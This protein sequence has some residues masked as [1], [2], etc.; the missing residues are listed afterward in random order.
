MANNEPTGQDKDQTASQAGQ[1]NTGDP[2]PDQ[3]DG[4][5]QGDGDDPGRQGG[6]EARIRQLSKMKNQYQSEAEHWKNIAARFAQLDEQDTR[7]HQQQP[8]AQGN[9]NQNQYGSD[10]VERAYRVLH[11]RG[12]ATTEDLERLAVRMKWDRMHD[13]NERRYNKRGNRYP[14]YNREEVEEYARTH[15]IGDPNAAYRDMYFDEILDAVKSDNRG[16]PS[17]S[18]SKTEKPSRPSNSQKEPLTLDGFKEKLR[19]DPGFYDKL[20]EDPA[21]FD[22]MLSDLSEAS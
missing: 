22:A 17:G 19:E 9:Q 21:R 7:G 5:G 4:G 6:A 12:M 8:P 10:E 1:A 3:S 2:E 18:G 14:E 11:D 13:Q 20:A 16:R 15:N